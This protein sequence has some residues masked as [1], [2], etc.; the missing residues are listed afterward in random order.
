MSAG[1]PRADHPLR[2]G[3]QIPIITVVRCLLAVGLSLV[4]LGFDG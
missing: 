3:F 4:Y 1:R 2:I